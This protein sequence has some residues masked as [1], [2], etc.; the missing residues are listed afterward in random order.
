MDRKTNTIGLAMPMIY[1]AK[2]KR[3]MVFFQNFIPCTYRNAS[4]YWAKIHTR[5]S[6]DTENKFGKKHRN[7]RFIGSISVDIKVSIYCDHHVR[8]TLF[9]FSLAWIVSNFVFGPV[10]SF[11]IHVAT[12]DRGG[13]MIEVGVSVGGR[14]CQV[15]P[16]NFLWGSNPAL[17]CWNISLCRW[18][19]LSICGCKILSLWRWAIKFP[20][21]RTILRL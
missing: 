16:K 3:I 14:F 11:A 9:C 15:C 7:I 13:P 5:M 6:Q 17:S 8:L 4:V 10:V 19:A 12:L 1:S 18:I 21:T 20:R 2:K